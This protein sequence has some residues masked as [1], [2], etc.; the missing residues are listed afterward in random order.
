MEITGIDYYLTK[1][2]EGPFLLILGKNGV[3]LVLPDTIE[4]SPFCKQILAFGMDL[5]EIRLNISGN[6]EDMERRCSI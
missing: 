6:I 2:D 3:T 5:V 4:D 1:D